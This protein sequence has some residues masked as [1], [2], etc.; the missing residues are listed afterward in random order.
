[1]NLNKKIVTAIASAMLTWNIKPVTAETVAT[2]AP[3]VTPQAE[4]KPASPTVAPTAAPVVVEEADFDNKVLATVN[5]EPITGG[6]L[7]AYLSGRTSRMRGMKK[8]PPQMQNAA[9]NNLISVVL[10]A[11]AAREA[12]LDTRP[13]MVTSLKLYSDQ[14]LAQTL[15][16]EQASAHTP[17]EEALKKAYDEKYASSRQE[18]KAAHILVKTEEEAKQVIEQLGKGTDFAVVAKEKSIDPTS[19]K[20]G[21]LGWFDAS[22]MVKPFSDAVA[23]M[24]K[25]DVSTQPVKSQFGWH[26]IRLDETRTATP[27]EFNSVKS[28]LQ[29]ELQRKAL[30][31]Y[32]EQLR[33]KAKIE[34]KAPIAEPKQSPPPPTTETVPAEPVK[35]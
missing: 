26:V 22:Q 27:P 14:M 24:K 34:M 5:D 18:Y 33:N 19:N 1:M 28:Q 4:Q 9:L 10:L 8:P 16:Q 15:L 29:S 11:K 21:D 17:S 25:G 31:D 12:G 7:S 35:K 23:A 3:A 2:E 30:M 32:V 13:G 20:G 6:M